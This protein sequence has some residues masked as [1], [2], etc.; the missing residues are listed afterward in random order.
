M[1]T[2]N[3][4]TKP[5]PARRYTNTRRSAQA[6]QT[7]ADVLAAAVELFSEEGWAGTTIAGIAERAGVAPE[8]IYSGFGSKKKLLQQAADTTVVGDAEPVTFFEREWVQALGTGDL[9]DRYRRG[10]A[11]VAAANERGARVWRAC[12]DAAAADDEMEAWRKEKIAGRRLDTFRSFQLIL[13]ADLDDVTVSLLMAIYS[14]EMYVFFTED[15]GW[16]SEQYQQHILD[17]S[18]AIIRDRHPEL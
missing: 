4:A 13:G 18:L 16:T 3:S 15:C 6:A 12:V 1:A 7:R 5:K 14:G 11:V 9:D 8:T 17:A 2:K 10:M